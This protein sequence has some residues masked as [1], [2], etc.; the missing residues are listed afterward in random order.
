MP[1]IKPIAD[2]AESAVIM[3][4]CLKLRGGFTLPVLV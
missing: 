3:V 4:V 2:A 1:N